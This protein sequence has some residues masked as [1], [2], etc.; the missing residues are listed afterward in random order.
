MTESAGPEAVASR[1]EAAWNSHDMEAFGAL[2]QPDASFVNRFATYWRGVDG[3]VAGHRHIHETIYSDSTI[4]MDA[5]DVDRLSNDVAILHCWSRL[6]VGGAHP[7]GPHQID[8]LMLV[9]TTR[10]DGEWRIQA[11]EN[12][13]LAD[14]TSGRQVL[15]AS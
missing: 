3:I 13:T 6:T 14:P 9:V 5:P 4:K 8:T 2:F 15:R 10:R 11:A 1:F 7:A 12:V